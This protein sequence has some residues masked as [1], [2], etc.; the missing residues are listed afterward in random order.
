MKC[1][2]WHKH[3][4]MFGLKLNKNN[5]RNFYPLGVVARGSEAQLQVGEN[6]N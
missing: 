5:M 6:L 1:E 4:R 2:L 3:L